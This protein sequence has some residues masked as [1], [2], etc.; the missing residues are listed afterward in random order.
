MAKKHF[1]GNINLVLIHSGIVNGRQLL[2]NA[3][4]V[5]KPHRGTAALFLF[6][7]LLFFSTFSFDVLSLL[8]V[9]F[10]FLGAS[11]LCKQSIED[12]RLFCDSPTGHLSVHTLGT[13]SLK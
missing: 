4:S 1:K 13:T 6:Y 10:L 8:T 3:H 12:S 9:L 7:S 2:C 11:S 5:I